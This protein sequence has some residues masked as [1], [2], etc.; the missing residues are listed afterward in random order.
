MSLVPTPTQYLTDK[1]GQPVGVVLSYEAYQAWRN[2]TDLLLGLDREELQ[3]LA[4]GLLASENQLRLTAL[5]DK[6]R[7]ESLGEEEARELDA[8]LEQVDRLNLLKARAQYTLQ[9]SES[10]VTW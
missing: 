10:I 7:Q 1:E 8:L 2:D 5:L 9:Q 3:L 4:Q 6:N